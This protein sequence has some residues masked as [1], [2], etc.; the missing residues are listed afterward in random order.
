MSWS[1]L[2]FASQVELPDVIKG[3][4][5]LAPI[6]ALTLAA[7]RKHLPGVQVNS[8]IEFDQTGL[9]DFFI[10]VRRVSG[11]GLW[12]GDERFIDYAG[13]AVHVF[14]KDPDADTK[15]ALVSEAVRVVLRDS[16]RARE[17]YPGLGGFTSVRMDEE[18]TRKTDW[19][20]S[21][22]PV[23]FA[24]LPAGYQRYQTNYSLWVRKPLS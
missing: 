16:A 6:E 11:M 5:E 23:Q 12:D 18:P 3:K 4:V 1:D 24:D 7:L 14:A 20:A 21:S 13:L 2:P 8:L 22:G 15:G 9:D 17:F 19:A 10:L